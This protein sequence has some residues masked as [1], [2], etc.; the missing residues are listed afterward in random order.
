LS[1][2]KD[3]IRE[4]F[5]EVKAKPPERVR[6]VRRTQGDKAAERMR[7]AIALDKA[8]KNGARIPK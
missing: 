4:A 3:L 7:R 2:T 5:H 1:R 8:R 6:Q